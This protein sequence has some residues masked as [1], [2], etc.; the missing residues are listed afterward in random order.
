MSRAP[1][2]LTLVHGRI[3]GPNHVSIAH[4]WIDLNNGTVYDP[5]LSRYMPT[6]DYLKHAVVEHRYSKLEATR[7][8]ARF[9]HCGG[10]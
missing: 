3:A 10:W 5:V 2:T 9:G 7:M 4:A 8:V 6:A 1:K